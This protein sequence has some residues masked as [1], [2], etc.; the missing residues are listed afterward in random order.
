MSIKICK[1]LLIIFLGMVFTIGQ[2]PIEARS[3]GGGLKSGVKS[4]TAGHIKKPAAK[5]DSRWEQKADRNDNGYVDPHEAKKGKHR[6]M[7]QKSSTE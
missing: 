2:E 3:R 4:R 7:I 1:L 5:V 6:L